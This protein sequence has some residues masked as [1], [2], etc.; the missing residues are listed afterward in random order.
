MHLVVQVFYPGSPEIIQKQLPLTW[1]DTKLAGF[2]VRLS[3]WSW[4][5]IQYRR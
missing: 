5:K 1:R 2:R 3:E 4:Q